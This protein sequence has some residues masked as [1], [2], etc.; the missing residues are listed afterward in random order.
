MNNKILILLFSVASL[1][2]YSQQVSVVSF[3]ETSDFIPGADQRRDFNGDLCALVKIQVVDEV[4]DVEGNVMGDIMVK[5]VEKWVYMAKGSKKAN[6]HLKNHLPVNVEFNQYKVKALQGNRV[7][8]LVLAQKST[9]DKVK[10][11]K[12][13]MKDMSYVVC[14]VLG[15]RAGFISLKQDGIDGVVKIPVKEVL[16]IRYANGS[17]RKF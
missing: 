17:T 5:G 1:A 3:T 11:D 9:S 6:I 8:V 4:T 10:L 2:A 7:Y 13:D 16:R 14:K 15:V 12:I